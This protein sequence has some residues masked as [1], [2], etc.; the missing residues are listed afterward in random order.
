MAPVETSI[1]DA[2]IAAAR[3]SGALP[4]DVEEAEARTWLEEVASR[5]DAADRH[6]PKVYAGDAVLVRAADSSGT[7][8]EDEALGWRPFIGG[9]LEVAWA[10]GSHHSILDGEGA[11]VLAA[12]VERAAV[13]SSRQPGRRAAP[14]KKATPRFPNPRTG[15]RSSTSKE[16]RHS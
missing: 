16:R 11:R 15:V 3:A 10:P 8:P 14:A 5:I 9:D 6:R 1:V 13:A 7:A 12:I 2:A 4:P